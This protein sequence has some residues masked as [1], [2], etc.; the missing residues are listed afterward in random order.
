MENN[1]K[2]YLK[3]LWKADYPDPQPE[4]AEA[5]WERFADKAFAKKPSKTISL[6]P[7]WKYYAAAAAAIVLFIISV[8]FTSISASG[9]QL[10]ENTTGTIQ[11][12][13]LPDQSVVS[14]QPGSKLHYTKDFETNRQVKLEG[15]GYFEVRKNDTSPFVVSCNHTT[16]TVLGTSF[17]VKSLFDGGAE[18]ALYEGIVKMNVE[19][20]NKDWILSPGD[21]FV[22]SQAKAE[23]LPFDKNNNPIQPYIDFENT[24]LAEITDYIL[25]VYGYTILADPGILDERVTLRISKKES[26]E[27]IIK[28]ISTIYDL[29]SKTDKD[30]KEIRF[31]YNE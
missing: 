13:I 7:N 27:T 28:T 17:S 24:R 19:E 20:N 30:Q 21:L 9:F 2:R 14:L 1:L 6:R 26:L 29:D 23:I 25:K 16:T 5:S 31:F 11:E 22:Y 4:E 18:V 3:E 12:F 8:P 10:V 15:E